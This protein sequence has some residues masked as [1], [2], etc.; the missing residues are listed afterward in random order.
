MNINRT[1]RKWL[2]V[3]RNKRSS[4]TRSLPLPVMLREQPHRHWWLLVLSSTLGIK[5]PILNSNH[6]LNKRLTSLISSKLSVLYISFSIGTASEPFKVQIF[7]HLFSSIAGW[8]SLIGL[9][10]HVGFF[11]LSWSFVGLS[12][13]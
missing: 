9:E 12:K 4:S 2:T 10:T 6:S 5:D 13:V 11:V 1:G 8:F 3:K 7:I